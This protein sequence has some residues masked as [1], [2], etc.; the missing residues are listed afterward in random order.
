[1]FKVEVQGIERLVANLHNIGEELRTTAAK[2]GVKASCIVIEDAY[3]NNLPEGKQPKIKPRIRQVVAHKLW[4]FPDG[5][6]YAGI[7]GTRSG[8]ASHAHLIE[9]GTVYRKRT[10]DK[11]TGLG[12]IGGRFKFMMKRKYWNPKGNVVLKAKFKGILKKG[13]GKPPFSLKPGDPET[14]TGQ[15]PAFH[16][17]AL[18]AQTAMPQAE[19]A[20]EKA[21]VGALTRKFFG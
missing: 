9:D 16:C 10:G 14:R 3:R 17:L 20:F 2:E 7:V 8:M 12:G 19:A 6:G 15:M 5:T 1:M 4:K 11:K 13:S 21:F 18:A